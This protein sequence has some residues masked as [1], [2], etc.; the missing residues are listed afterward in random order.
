M[1]VANALGT[2]VLQAAGFLPF[3]PALC[4]H[5]LGEELKLPSVQSWWCGHPESLRYVLDHLSDLVIKSAYPTQGEDPVFAQDLT[6]EQ[7][8]ELALQI[9]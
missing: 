1:A 5:L 2:G 6:R 9:R 8:S 4:R 3:L 7:L